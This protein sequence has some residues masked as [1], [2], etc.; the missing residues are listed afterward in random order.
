L[1]ST[2]TP[3]FY[4]PACGAAVLAR[5]V[6]GCNQRELAPHSPPPDGGATALQRLGANVRRRRIELGL[7]PH[8]AAERAGVGLRSW[9]RLEAAEQN[10]SITLL[11]CI[12]AVLQVDP[13]DLLARGEEVR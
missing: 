12:A 3:P 6:R 7:T 10:A 4:C 13:A 5:K 9:Q 8:G 2:A 11:V 1:L